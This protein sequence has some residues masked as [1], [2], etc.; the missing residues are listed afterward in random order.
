MSIIIRLLVCGATV[1]TAAIAQEK[2][3]KKSPIRVVLDPGHGGRDRGAMVQNISES[4]ITLQVTQKLQALLKRDPRF[5]VS[6]TRHRDEYVT[7]NE[8]ARLAVNQQADLFLSIH[9]NSSPDTGA[10][11]AEFY[12]QNQLPPDEEAM[13]LAH[14]E[15]ASQDPPLSREKRLL[16][17]LR[18]AEVS[19]EAMTILDDLLTNQRVVRSSQLSKSLRMNWQGSR[20][21]ASKS[22]RQAPFF[23]LSHLNAPSSL[24]E[25]GFLTNPSDLA[26]LL[27]PA[28]QTKMA[29][30]LYRGLIQY[31]ESIT[32]RN[33]FR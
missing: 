1:T 28:H 16:E 27:S 23:V 24:V 29:E 25:I 30:D 22:V 9:V 2:K 5:T 18:G 4:H 31:R 17:D 8:R 10:H 20:K 21:E 14:K 32:N 11:G 13:F 26:E 19:T 7:L 6:V 12:F 33:A 3:K 15:N